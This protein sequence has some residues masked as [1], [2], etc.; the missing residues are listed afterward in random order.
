V[1]GA[2]HAAGVV[3]RDIKPSNVI[4]AGERVVVTDFGL[5]RMEDI[6]RLTKTGQLMG[7]LDYMSP[8]QCEG[9]AIDHRTDLYSAGIILYEMLVG[10]PPFRRETPGAILK[11]HLT[12]APSRLDAIRADLPPGLADVVERLLAKKPDERFQNA[13]EA[14]RG[15]QAVADPSMTVTFHHGAVPTGA[16]SGHVTTTV[17]SSKSK[18]WILWVVSAVVLVAIAGFALKKMNRKPKYAGRGTRDALLTTIHQSIRRADFATF[19]ACFEGRLLERHLPEPRIEKF[20]ERAGAV[21]DFE[22]RSEPAPMGGGVSMRFVA[23]PALVTVFGLKS[24]EPLRVVI[25]PSEAEYVVAEIREGGGKRQ[26]LDASEMRRV[27]AEVNAAVEN[28]FN[29]LGENVIRMAARRKGRRLTNEELKQLVARIRSTLGE[30]RAEYSIVERES[31]YSRDHA[32]V[33][34]RCPELTKLLGLR[35][36][37]IPVTLKRDPRNGTWNLE[38]RRRNGR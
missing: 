25:P 17:V 2:A 5:A 9:E 30:R 16:T 8:E 37:R 1:L 27:K 29:H 4:L 11:G 32:R 21:T 20:R 23:S 33:V 28:F 24:R 18:R 31:L 19:S 26:P 3:H 38:A 10:T 22:F 12:E 14:L 6:T 15:L 36:D 7:T 34:V 13:E 35:V